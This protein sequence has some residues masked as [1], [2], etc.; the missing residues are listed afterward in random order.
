MKKQKP[1]GNGLESKTFETGLG[2][3]SFQQ[4]NVPA[5]KSPVYIPNW[6][7]SGKTLQDIAKEC[8]SRAEDQ[9][10]PEHTRY[11]A[12]QVS[13]LAEDL[14]D[15]FRLGFQKPEA[16]EAMQTGILLGEYYMRLALSEN[17]RP[18]MSGKRSRAAAKKKGRAARDG[19]VREFLE[20]KVKDW[21]NKSRG[22]LLILAKK[23]FQNSTQANLSRQ[24]R[25]LKKADNRA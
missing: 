23:E 9:S 7:D 11:L 17:E 14:I 25:R 6:T 21:R 12:R 24:I 4:V 10:T 16:L 18:A 20:T 8:R 2:A 5:W 19:S 22:S 3:I 13:L 15:Q 1:F